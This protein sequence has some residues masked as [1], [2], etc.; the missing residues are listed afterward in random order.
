MR[1]TVKCVVTS[2]TATRVD[3]VA[4]TKFRRNCFQSSVSS[5]TFF[6]DL[7]A[8]SA[9]TFWLSKTMRSKQE[10]IPSRGDG[11]DAAAEAGIEAEAEAE[12]EAVT[13]TET[14]GDKE[15][16]KRCVVW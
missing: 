14:G 12:A 11:E 5:G 3:A 10:M 9:N 4:V 6:V 7:A 16:S 2:L 15:E 13:A 1:D 8:I